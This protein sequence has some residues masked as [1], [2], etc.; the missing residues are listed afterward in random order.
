MVWVLR[1]TYAYTKEQLA[2]DKDGNSINNQYIPAREHALNVRMDY[3]RQIS[4]NYGLNI[5]LQGRVLS[6]VEN[7]ECTRTIMM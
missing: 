2:K 6:G 7:V 4:S 3:D 5:G 1:I